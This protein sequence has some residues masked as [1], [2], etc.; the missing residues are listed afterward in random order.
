[1]SASESAPRVVHVVV[2]GE[3]GG[4]ER[5]LCD[6]ASR[7][8]SGAE[9][10]VALL[11]PNER[12]GELL[13]GAGLRVHDRGRT[14]EG[15][16]PYLWSS[17]GPRDAA[18]IAGVLAR[19]RA[20]IAHLHTF[21]SQVVGTRA[22]RRTGARVLRTE[23]STRAFHDPSCWPFSRWSLARADASVAISEA[24]RRA[25]L[26]RAP[27]ASARMRVVHDGVDTAR[28]APATAP[29]SERVTFAIVGR[30]DARKGVDLALAAL[31]R[32][33]G[34]R[35]EVVGDGEERAPL[36]ALARRA[37]VAERVTFR[38]FVG[39]PRP[40]L[41]HVDAALCTSRTEGLGIAL[42]EAMAMGRPILGFAVG[43][44]RE[45]VDDGRTG[46]LVPPGDVEALAARM[47][48]LAAAADRG[49]ALGEAARARVVERFSVQAMCAGYARVYA[50]LA[51]TTLPANEARV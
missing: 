12:L 17:L 20:T 33:D 29:R 1:V 45:V 8:E 27:W 26:A 24:V 36:E 39:D 19:E 28:F 32:V 50:E 35:L 3:V 30:L 5:M 13:R 25:A 2:A 43:G 14:R 51:V 46:W 48:D 9:H 6:L 38:G 22:A 37:G 16:L 10:S 4:A 49:R 15:P 40:L 21:A 47:R 44:V 41:A 11:T 23:H 31:A 7:P 42:L 18:W 34:V